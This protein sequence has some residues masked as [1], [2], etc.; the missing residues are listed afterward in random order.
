[1]WSE[2]RQLQASPTVDVDLWSERHGLYGSPASAA[3]S[4]EALGLASALGGRVNTMHAF[5]RR[6]ASPLSGARESHSESTFDDCVAWWPDGAYGEAPSA[7]ARAAMLAALRCTLQAG[8]RGSTD[9]VLALA[10]AAGWA[11]EAASGIAP[12]GCALRAVIRGCV[13]RDA[14]KLALATS[15]SRLIRRLVPEP[16]REAAGERGLL[17]HAPAALALLLEE[18]RDVA[19]AVGGASGGPGG[20]GDEDDVSAVEERPAAAARSTYRDVALCDS[21][22]T[23][24]R[25]VRPVRVRVAETGAL[26]RKLHS[27]ELLLRKLPGGDLSMPNDA[28]SKVAIED[29]VDD[30][31]AEALLIAH[32]NAPESA[33]KPVLEAQVRVPPAVER[34][35]SIAAAALR[36]ALISNAGRDWTAATTRALAA[37]GSRPLSLH[38]PMALKRVS[39]PALTL[40][41]DGRHRAFTGIPDCGTNAS[42]YCPLRHKSELVDPDTLASQLANVRLPTGLGFAPLAADDRVPRELL[43]VALDTSASMEASF[44]TDAEEDYGAAGGPLDISA[45]GAEMRAAI[46][47]P[48]PAECA[49]A[50][51]RLA[52][53]AE[54]PSL[55]ALAGRSAAHRVGVLQLIAEEDAVLRALQHHEGVRRI[56][57]VLDAA[58]RAA[59]A[60]PIEPPAAPAPGAIPTFCVTV[61]LPPNAAGMRRD[62]LLPAAPTYPVSFILSRIEERSGIPAARCQLF[63]SDDVTHRRPFPPDSTLAGVGLRQDGRSIDAVLLGGGDWEEREESARDEPIYFRINS[64]QHGPTITAVTGRA[65]WTKRTLKLAIFAGAPELAPAM[66]AFYTNLHDGKDGT[67]L[68]ETFMPIGQDAGYPLRVTCAKMLADGVGLDPRKP[69]ELWGNL[70]G[71]RLT[72]EAHEAVRR[73]EKERN[74]QRLHAV[75]QLFGA[76]ANRLAGFDTATHM[77]LVSFSSRVTV[78]PATP[79]FERF[80]ADVK[81]LNSG[82]DTALFDALRSSIEMASMTLRTVKPLRRRVLILTD[83]EDSCSNKSSSA[84]SLARRAHAAG[85]VVDAILIGDAAE[86]GNASALLLRAICAATGGLCLAPASLR[87]ALQMIEW[88]TLL[89]AGQRAPASVSTMAAS[90]L[91]AALRSDVTLTARFGR[92]DKLF[93]T[94]AHPPRL[95]RDAALDL[96][97]TAAAAALTAAPGA[98]ERPPAAVLKLMQELRAVTSREVLGD[99][100]DQIDVYPASSDIGFWRVVVQGSEGTPYGGGVFALSVRFPP[101]YPMHAPEIRFL[102]RILHANANAYGRCVLHSGSHLVTGLRHA[103]T[104]SRLARSKH[105]PRHAG[106][107]VEQR[108]FGAAYARRCVFSF[109]SVLSSSHALLS[110]SRNRLPLRA[111][112]DDQPSEHHARSRLLHQR[113]RV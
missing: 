38:P 39:P 11:M 80:V 109:Q 105:L 63:R 82:G 73:R 27:R 106:Q 45:V 102:T 42:L 40:G 8:G 83:G 54:L 94:A 74:M 78:T 16:M 9:A 3:A 70:E 21:H 76:F 32:P 23:H 7:E 71:T 47:R 55:A 108:R 60:G 57:A 33:A 49:S 15:I 113:R 58:P 85:V 61:T 2:E 22:A 62:L 100:V 65:S 101:T 46:Q 48:P 41:S 103:S 26:G 13:L 95:R 75:Q 86:E 67:K 66:H 68:W 18:A 91:E 96:P 19:A 5:L 77:G 34:A 12:G 25:L 17:T 35:G 44:R 92:R 79:L 50:L 1:V 31:E 81:R 53:S 64:R 24:R 112:R 43:V 36:D 90:E 72:R 10:D 69:I 59:A 111:A 30:A 97:A 28:Y 104:H 51:A 6:A 4:L 56:A 93:I 14:D 52:E 87:D 107:R 110:A 88:E 84:S 20:E 37:P 29:V 98:G 99:M 89:D